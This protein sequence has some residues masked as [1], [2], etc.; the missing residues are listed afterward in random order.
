MRWSRRGSLILEEI[1][2]I[3]V[4]IAVLIALLSIISGVIKGLSLSMGNIKVNISS[5]VHTFVNKIWKVVSGALNL[6]MK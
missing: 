1:I 3:A 5:S 4:S 2:L 6:K